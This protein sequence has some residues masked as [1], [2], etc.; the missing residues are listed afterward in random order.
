MSDMQDASNLTELINTMERME[1]EK[2]KVSVDDV[3]HAVG[4]R[5]FGPLLLLAGLITL[6]PII[7]DIPGMPTL[8][9]A[10]VLLT[11]VQ[12]LLGRETFWLPKWLLSRSLSRNKFD[13]AIHYMKKPARWVDS[14]LGVR[15]A[16]M[17]GYIGIRVTAVMC[18]FI[19]L[20]MPPMEFIPFS[21]NGAGLALTLFG[22]G[23]VARDGIMLSLGFLLTGATLTVVLINVL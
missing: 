1:R 18:L 7:G 5:S 11:S 20:A 6:A 9:A 23:L 22:L 8:M 3:V 4:R 16:W 12:L 15:L 14:L 21:A 13:K 10:L 19:A 2:A 17:T